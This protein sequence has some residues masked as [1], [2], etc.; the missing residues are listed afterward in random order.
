MLLMELVQG[1]EVGEIGTGTYDR[2]A[3]HTQPGRD[4]AGGR[5][6]SLQQNLTLACGSGSGISAGNGQREPLQKGLFQGCGLRAPAR[7]GPKG[8]TH[9]GINRKLRIPGIRRDNLANA[10][11]LRLW[12]DLPHVLHRVPPLIFGR[13]IRR[14]V[15]EAVRSVL[16]GRWA[17]RGKSAASLDGRDVEGRALQ[18]AERDVGGRVVAVGIDRGF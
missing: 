3:I 8:Q 5:T 16:F 7:Q 15:L 6:H 10:I 2:S 9:L 4:S 18:R 14:R 13:P 1:V 12:A 11:L 17:A